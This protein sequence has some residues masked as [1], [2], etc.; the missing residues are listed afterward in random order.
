MS[1]QDPKVSKEA[2]HQVLSQL[3]KAQEAHDLDAMVAVYA[4][5]GFVD[6]QAMRGYFKG[7]IEQ[8]VLKNRHV[9]LS[10]SETFIFRDKALVRPVVYETSGGKRSFSFQFARQENDL[11]RII[12]N[13]RSY[14]PGDSVYSEELARHAAKVAGPRGML[15]SRKLNVPVERAWEAISTRDGLN[16]WWLTRDVELDLRPGGLFKHHWIN[17]VADFK[18]CEY[19]VFVEDPG[20]SGLKFYMRFDLEPDGEG[21][22]FHFYDAFLGVD[23]PLTLPWTSSGWHGTVDALETALTG[24]KISN[25]FG[26]GGEFYWKYLRNY[27]RYSILATDLAPGPLTAEEWREAYLQAPV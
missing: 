18:P 2:V 3:H 19:I 14:L 24:R 17:R 20:K 8:D 11:W 9:D 26:L 27:H 13:R 25:D 15:W 5:Q 1:E 12:D 10:H 7:L 22:I 23:N 4:D 6:K 16:Q 21:T